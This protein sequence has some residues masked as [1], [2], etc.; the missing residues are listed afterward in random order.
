MKPIAKENLLLHLVAVLPEQTQEEK[1]TLLRSLCTQSDMELRPDGIYMKG[2]GDN[3]IS[4]EEIN[5]VFVCRNCA[6]IQIKDL[7]CFLVELNLQTGQHGV[8]CILPQLN[9]WQKW[10]LKW[11]QRFAKSAHLHT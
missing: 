9:R 1:V 8:V 3:H 7:P 11:K 10:I 2:G 5:L 4:F 6:Y